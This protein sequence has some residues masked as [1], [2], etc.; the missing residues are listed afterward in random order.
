MVD[1]CG[2]GLR[3]VRLRS[4]GELDSVVPEYAATGY[5]GSGVAREK[6]DVTNG[7]EGRSEKD[8]TP[9]NPPEPMTQVT[10]LP[11]SD[12]WSHGKI[13]SATMH[14]LVLLLRACQRVSW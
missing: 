1:I 2:K 11:R 5:R 4:D 9:D 6:A 12:L 7:L 8:S 13:T 14:R 3:N 10:W